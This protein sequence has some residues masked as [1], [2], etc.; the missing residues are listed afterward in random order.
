M[1]GLAARHDQP[2]RRVAHVARTKTKRLV[3]KVNFALNTVGVEEQHDACVRRVIVDARD[4]GPCRQEVRCSPDGT[5]AA[6]EVDVLAHQRRRCWDIARTFSQEAGPEHHRL[7]A[8][9][10]DRS[11]GAEWLQQPKYPPNLL[12]AEGRLGGHRRLPERTRSGKI[13]PCRLCEPREKLVLPAHLL[14]GLATRAQVSL[15]RF[16]RRL[17]LA[18]ANTG[19]KTFI[20]A[21]HRLWI[22]PD[23]HV[24][25]RVCTGAFSPVLSL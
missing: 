7:P 21:L 4:P 22:L 19:I 13:N 24:L 17:L 20:A 18:G 3:D 25:S 15:V 2:H 10:H 9:E 14:D 23:D 8:D 12:V 16:T 5:R 11:I 6:L 1:P